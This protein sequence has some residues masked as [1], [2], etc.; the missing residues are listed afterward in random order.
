MPLFLRYSKKKILN[1]ID[2]H[3]VKKYYEFVHT[4]MLGRSLYAEQLENWYKLFSKDQILIIKSEEFAIQTNKIMN[5][6]FNFLELEHFDIP[7]N[8]KKNKIHYD[9]MKKETRDDLIEFFRPY[10][11]KLYS[12]IGK[13]F[14]WEH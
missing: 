13:N 2:K 10:N 5:E 11:Q 4:S 12:L 3:N 9:M 6:I 14:D 1:Q 8:S 7:D